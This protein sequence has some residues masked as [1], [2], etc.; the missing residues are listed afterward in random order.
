MFGLNSI[1]AA[2]MS[3]AP[4]KAA[5]LHEFITDPYRQGIYHGGILCL[6]FY[7]LYFGLGGDSG[8]ALTAQARNELMKIPAEIKAELKEIA[9]TNQDIR[10][11]SNLYHLCCYP[12]KNPFFL[13]PLLNPTDGPYYRSWAPKDMLDNIK[14]PVYLVSCWENEQ[15]TLG[16]FEAWDK[17]KKVPK[18]LMITPPGFLERPF[19]EYHDEMLRWYDHHFKGVNNGIMEEPPVKLYITGINQWRQ[20]NEWP[21]AR[22]KWTK[23]YFRSHSRLLT[24]PESLDELPPNGF[25][26]PPIVVAS[27][28][29]TLL[30]TTSPMSKDTEITGPI[31]LHFFAE[32]DSD[33]TNWI[34]RL[35]DIDLS[36]RRTMLSRG[37][38]K[39]THR[40]LDA[41]QS[42][43]FRPYHPHTL[44]SLAPVQPGRVYQYDIELIPIGHVF[45]SGHRLELEIMSA[46]LPNDPLYLESFPGGHHLPLSRT[47]SHKIYLDR[48]HPSHLYLPLI[49]SYP[50]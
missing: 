29:S 6:F 33:D 30:Y 36:G 42:K 15:Y 19:H 37:Y 24:E 38:L 1:L 47:V 22:T 16:V 21:L 23:L 28:I 44:E 26:Q 43:P 13:G 5:F 3:P 2:C 41:L 48:N 49:D 8:L 32:I 27:E 17:I 4:L 18:K 7:G 14:C 39:A 50:F 20:E 34:I 46:E 35:H 10:Y 12:E 9:A 45:K 40:A 11:Y 31:G 25:V